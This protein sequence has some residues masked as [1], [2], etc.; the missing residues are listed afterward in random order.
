[1]LATVEIVENAGAE[2]IQLYLGQR[3]GTARKDKTDLTDTH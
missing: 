2:P 1:M 3:R